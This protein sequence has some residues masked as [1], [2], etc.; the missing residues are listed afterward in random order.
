M[1]LNFLVM[2]QT[3][4][5]LNEMKLQLQKWENMLRISE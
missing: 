4:E 3:Q 1:K 5:S 2:K